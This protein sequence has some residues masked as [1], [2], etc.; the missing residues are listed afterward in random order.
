VV[1]AREA[2]V[3]TEAEP[4]GE[5]KE[6]EAVATTAAGA[7]AAEDREEEDAA[8][9]M[10]RSVAAEGSACRGLPGR[11]E[12]SEGTC[13]EEGAVPGVDEEGRLGGMVGLSCVLVQ[14]KERYLPVRYR[15]N[16]N[17]NG[18]SG[19]RRGK[20]TWLVLGRVWLDSWRAID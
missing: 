18:R 4:D 20:G 1:P 3:D 7:A 12:R 6:E 17:I 11:T 14:A 2:G 13:M 9:A 8:A 10:G 19:E 5:A 15:F 16:H